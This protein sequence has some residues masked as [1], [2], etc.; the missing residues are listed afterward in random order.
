M[1]IVLARHGKPLL[2][3]TTPI[4]GHELGEW[5][6][7]YDRAGITREVAPPERVRQLA[8]SVGC[9]VASDLPRSIESA[10]WLVSAHN[11]RIEPEL[12]EACLP[13]SI[14][15]SVRLPPAAWVVLA[16]AAWWLDW[17]RS[18]ETVATT[19]ERAGRAA[20]RLSALAREYGSVLV[21]GHGMFNR[22]IA[23]H[24][25]TRGWRGPRALPTAYWATATF[26]RTE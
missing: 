6:R 18:P 26:A 5:V 11:V 3:D 20:G 25:L 12:R 23:A 16:R 8:G 14:G 1:E 9:V 4:P 19:R 24:L 22:F 13:E 2:P 10:A 7:R 21:V 17:C 15:V